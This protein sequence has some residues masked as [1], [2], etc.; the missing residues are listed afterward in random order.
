VVEEKFHF[1]WK[2]GGLLK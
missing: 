2:A 1:R